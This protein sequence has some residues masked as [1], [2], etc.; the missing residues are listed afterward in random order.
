LDLQSA[1]G[2]GTAASFSP[3]VRQA[4]YAAPRLAA[5]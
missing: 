2:Q 1:P 5:G 4:G 3:P